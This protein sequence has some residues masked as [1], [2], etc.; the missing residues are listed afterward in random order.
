MQQTIRSTSLHFREGNSDK[1][2][3][4]A[5]EACDGGHVVTFAYGRRGT[6]LSTGTK[7][8]AP[9]PLDE[10][11]KIHDRLVASKLAKG[12]KADGEPA[13]PYRQSGNEGEDSGIRCQLLNPVEQSEVVRLLTDDRHCLQEK[14]DGRR[15]LD[16]KRGGTVTGAN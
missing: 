1:V 10:A 13:T 5:I 6:T 14:L 11:T 7:T 16:R 2:Y 12:Y 15:M 8:T 9:V 3:H 4:A